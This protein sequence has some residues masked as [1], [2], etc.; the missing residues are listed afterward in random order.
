MTR[1]FKLTNVYL[2]NN[3]FAIPGLF[4]DP[5]NAHTGYFTNNSGLDLLVWG[6]NNGTGVPLPGLR[7]V[8]AIPKE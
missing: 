3:E 1:R 5:V 8:T 6:M 7:P 2:P 4:S